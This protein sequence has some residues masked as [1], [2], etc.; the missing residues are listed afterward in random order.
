MRAT[1]L[2]ILASGSAALTAS[3]AATDVAPALAPNRLEGRIQASDAYASF[4]YV[5][6]L[7]DAKT[8]VRVELGWRA[9][10]RAFLRYG[11]SYAIYYAGGVGHYY[12]KK[13]YV[14]FDAG[15]ELARLKKEYAGVDIGGEP[16]P[17]FLLSQWD[18]LLLGR[19]LKATL[20]LQ[21]APRLGWLAELG[22]WTP[23]GPVFRR[24]LVEVEIREDGF[25]QRVK[26]G[27]TS[28]M[29]ALTVAVD[30]P[31]DDALFEPPPREG[32]TD[33]P[34]SA[35]DDLARALEDSF[36]RWAIETDAGSRTIETLVAADVERLYEPSKMVSILKE[37]LEKSLETWKA[38]N[39]DAK[40]AVLHEKLQVDKG[41]TLGSVEVMEKDIQANFERALDRSFRSMPAPPSRAFMRDVAN[42]WREA[43]AAVVQRRIH[44]PFEKVFDDKLRE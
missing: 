19:G 9:P 33:L 26:A 12:V 1:F 5:A 29:K 25:L 21:R 4:H 28:E 40:K 10:D 23:D 36:R 6:E 30:V 3:C 20:G 39:K 18:A 14:K 35:R 17:S 24:D 38:E 32:L 27:S 44:A 11:S 34:P 8:S 42:R 41:K 2:L 13:G 22:T 37:S 16:A 15:A 7:K 43:T 31:L